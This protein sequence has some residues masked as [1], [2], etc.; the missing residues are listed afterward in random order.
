VFI[1]IDNWYVY[2]T[3]NKNGGIWVKGTQSRK[4][5]TVMPLLRDWRNAKF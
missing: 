1:I 2:E 4:Q 3:E 5:G